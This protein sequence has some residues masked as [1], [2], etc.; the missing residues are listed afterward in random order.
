MKRWTPATIVLA[1]LAVIG[2]AA[3]IHAHATDT[4]SKPP[5]SPGER[6]VVAEPAA[7]ATPAA[8]PVT[9][10]ASP[11]TS[12]APATP[13]AARAVVEKPRP[14]RTRAPR[15]SVTGFAMPTNATLAAHDCREE[16]FDDR[17][18]FE[19]TYG[20][21]TS[22]IRR[23]ARFELARARAEC[24][25]DAIEDPFDHR[26]EYGAGRLALTLCVRDSLT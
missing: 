7:P 23:C 18:E 6:V 12:A 1:P 15:R 16:S 22:A 20:R 2:S 3:A 9:S 21:G 10:A 11:A 5:A 24:R 19:L 4:D 8:A 13:A 17:V 14:A 26:S 25:A